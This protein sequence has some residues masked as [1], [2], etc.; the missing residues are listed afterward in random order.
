[1]GKKR[2]T[3]KKLKEDAFVSATFEAGHFVQENVTSIILGIVGII[4]AISMIWMYTNY[5]GQRGNEAELALFKA[6][7]L[8]IN[9]QYALAASDFE[10]VSEEYSGTDAGKKAVFFA[11]D[12][13]F[14]AGDLNQALTTFE[15]CRDKL[16]G[17]APLMLNATVGQA[18]VYEELKDFDKSIQYYQE[19][20]ETAVYD[21]QKLEIL[22]AMSRVMAMAGRN[23]EA[24]EMME[25]IIQDY[26]DNPRTGKVIE[27]KAEM[28][29]RYFANAGT[30]N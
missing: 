19:A 17:D 14:K 20:L 22:D 9:G 6:Q 10:R 16:S 11:G 21:Y 7:N 24:L 18:A 27:Q 30:G 4:V 2:I 13:H 1:M 3:K 23:Q 12:S 26:P 29:A 8:Y 15:K 25:R 5:R 28:L